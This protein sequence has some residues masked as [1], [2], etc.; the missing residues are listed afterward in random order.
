MPGQDSSQ[1][2]RRARRASP[3]E[4]LADGSTVWHFGG[5]GEPGR[6]P[7]FGVEP[8]ALVE[9]SNSS[10]A[11]IGCRPQQVAVGPAEQ[12]FGPTTKSKAEQARRSPSQPM[13]APIAITW[14][15][16]RQT[17]LL[18]QQVAQTAQHLEETQT[19]RRP[20]VR[21]DGSLLLSPFGAEQY[22]PEVHSATYR[23]CLGNQFGAL[24]SRPVRT[25]AGE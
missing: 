10:G 21:Q 13:E 4:P 18:G 15:L 14:H 22:Q 19:G 11:V 16:V 25:R 3:F 7:Q 8:P 17:P 6:A 5:A 20:L 1:N 24:C 12:Q 2:R 9:Y 23:C